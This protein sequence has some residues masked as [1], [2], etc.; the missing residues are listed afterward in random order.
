MPQDV[1][2]YNYA[3]IIFEARWNYYKT[4]IYKKP[5]RPVILDQSPCK[6]TRYILQCKS[7]PYG[8]LEYIYP[9]TPF[10]HIRA[11]EHI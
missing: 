1:W 11:L 3:K 8:K 5:V 6:S 9:D 7:G 2:L 4:G 10:D